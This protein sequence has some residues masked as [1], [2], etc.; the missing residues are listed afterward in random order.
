MFQAFRSLLTV[1]FHLN[2]G[3]PQGRFPSIFNST[4]VRMFSV[5]SL[6]LTYPNHST[7]LLLTTIAIYRCIGTTLHGFLQYLL[8]YPV[9]LV[10]T[11]VRR[12]SLI[13]L[14]VAPFSYLLLSYAFHLQLTLAMFCS[15]KPT[16]VESLSASEIIGINSYLHA[17]VKGK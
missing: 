14:P 3:P 16:S 17:K 8:I 5:S 9:N 7:L 6:L 10:F 4:N 12:A 11:M 2:F 1:S 15:R 13:G